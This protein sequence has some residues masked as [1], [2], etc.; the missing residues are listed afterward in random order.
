[1]TVEELNTLEEIVNEK[2]RQAL[3][4]SVKVYEEGDPELTEVC[5]SYCYSCTA[6]VLVSARTAEMYCLSSLELEVYPKIIK[7]VYE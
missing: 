6:T 3:S 1:M 5:L 7:E 2:I 4:V